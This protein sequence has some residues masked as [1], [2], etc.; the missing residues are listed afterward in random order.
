M[1]ADGQHLHLRTQAVT[2]ALEFMGRPVLAWSIRIFPLFLRDAVY[3]FVAR[4]RRRGANNACPL[5][6]PQQRTRFL[7]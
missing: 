5:P 7:P 3:G 6:T 2:R 4:H 1:L